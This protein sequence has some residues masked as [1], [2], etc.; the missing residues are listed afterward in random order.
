MSPTTLRPGARAL[1]A[2]LTSLVVVGVPSAAL[3]DTPPTP[4]V[5]PSASPTT[6]ASP[7][8]ST[9]GSP[10]PTATDATPTPTGS[11]TPSG[12]PS[13]TPTPTN[14]PRAAAA[15][16][17][18][19][20]PGPGE[21]ETLA[22]A[23]FVARTLAQYGDHYVYPDASGNLDPANYPDHGNTIDGMLTLAATGTHQA[24][25]Q[26]SLAWLASTIGSYTGADW[27]D[28]YVGPTAKSIIGVV[29][30][31]G[32]AHAV[33]GADLVATLRGLETPS[34]RFSDAGSGDY[35]ITITQA[36]ATIALAR[37]GE[38]LTTPSVQFLLDQQCADGGFRGDLTGSGC[39]SDP[40]ATAFAAQA[41][42]AVDGSLLCWADPDA[43][44]AAAATGARDAL[45]FLA[46]L[47]GPAGGVESSGDAANA[48]TTGVAAQAF[49]AGG[50]TTAADAAVAF[51][52]TLQYGPGAPAALQGGI[53][54]SDAKRSTTTPGDSDLRATPQAA[55][56]LSGRTLLDVAA[57]D[58][59][60]PVGTDVCPAQ[61]TSTP[62]TSTSPT[63]STTSTQPAGAPASSPSATV[64]TVATGALAQTGA[65]PLT[66]VLV[67]LA[68]LVLGAA[69]VLGSRRRGAHA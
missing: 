49:I 16:A 34:G 43:T 32:D 25:A 13:A 29:A 22:A 66:P 35:S 53:A 21:P 4:S 55:L 40:D 24:Q 58:V 63:S 39:V 68:L 69:A 65:S 62:T 18:A 9:T 38:P 36:L 27:G 28:T 46:G 17:P 41:L 50:R 61:P 5:T 45:D 37:A 20:L 2:L 64:A 7:T 54:F 23:D 56:A 57:P 59:T 26:A 33:G 47:Q 51:L 6:P 30:L 1:G 60:D 3:A 15:A 10:T 12:S 67:G 44:R 8:P 14:T 48:N 31:G 42:L 11:P 19:A 52:A